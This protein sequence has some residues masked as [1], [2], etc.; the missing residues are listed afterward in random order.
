MT[1]RAMAQF[2]VC[3]NARCGGSFVFRSNGNL[4]GQNTLH[5]MEM[6]RRDL[7]NP[8]L[9]YDLH[10]ECVIISAR[11]A[12]YSARWMCLLFQ[13][14]LCDFTTAQNMSRRFT[15]MALVYSE[16]IFL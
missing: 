14:I 15:G 1:N 4:L 12:I 8:C 6:S 16:T 3:H 7:H 13:S 10:A 11:G 2:F 9:G 5:V